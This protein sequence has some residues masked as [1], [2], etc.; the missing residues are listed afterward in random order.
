ME[1]HFQEKKR[2]MRFSRLIKGA[3]IMPATGIKVGY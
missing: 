3:I 2:N 1:K